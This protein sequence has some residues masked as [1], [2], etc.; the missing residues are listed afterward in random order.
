VLATGACLLIVIN[1]CINLPPLLAGLCTVLCL[2]CARSQGSSLCYCPRCLSTPVIFC[3]LCYNKEIIYS[4]MKI[5]FL[6]Y[7]NLHCCLRSSYFRD[8]NFISWLILTRSF[9][10]SVQSLQPDTSTV[11]NVCTEIV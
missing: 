4:R 3:H 11:L 7:K 10:H 5:N 8:T 2:N 1:P 6:N 9:H